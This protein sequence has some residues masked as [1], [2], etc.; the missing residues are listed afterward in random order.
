MRMGLLPG[1][2]RNSQRTYDWVLIGVLAAI[3]VGMLYFGLRPKG[4]SPANNVRW[5]AE[6]PGLAFGRYAVAYTG[7]HDF[8]TLTEKGLSVVFAGRPEISSRPDLVAD[9]LDSPLSP[10]RLDSLSNS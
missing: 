3:V 10:A 6:G 4:Y 8:S 2:Y 1:S 9:F 5:A 7:L